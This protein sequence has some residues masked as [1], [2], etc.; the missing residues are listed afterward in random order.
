MR[1]LISAAAACPAVV[2]AAPAWAN[3]PPPDV[4]RAFPDAMSWNE[5]TAAGMVLLFAAMVFLT[6][7]LLKRW[8][9][10]SETAV[11]RLIALVL[12]VSSTLFLVVLG[13]STEQIG[14]ALGLLGTIAGYVLGRADR[15]GRGG[16]EE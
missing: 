11:V 2:L 12:I 13:F 10:Y 1:S 14:A 5:L 4:A 15:G 16:A 3:Q 8:G 7:V 9:G 6:A